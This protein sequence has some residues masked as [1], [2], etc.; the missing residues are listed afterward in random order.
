MYMY[1][2][3]VFTIEMLQTVH[4][5]AKDLLCAT[6]FWGTE[7]YQL[8]MKNTSIPQWPLKA[9]Q[10]TVYP[11]FWSGGIGNKRRMINCDVNK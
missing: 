9:D 5:L 10:Y 1:M 6:I 2:Y 11:L 8:A 3:S 4:A 7:I